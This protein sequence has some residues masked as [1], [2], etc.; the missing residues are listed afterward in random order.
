G[1]PP[2][3]TFTMAFSE[4]AYDER[5]AA[6]AV[7]RHIGSTH[8]ELAAEANLGGRLDAVVRSF[9]EPFGNPTALLVDELARTTR[10]HVTVALAGD[11]GDEV[12]AGYPRYRGGVLARRYRRLPR[13]LR[14]SVLRPLARFI[15]ESASGRHGLRRARE[16]LSSAD[17]P[18]AEMYAA[19][20]EYFTPAER[21]ALLGEAVPAAS[22]IAAAYAEAGSGD[23]LDAM[24]ETDLRTFLPGNLLAYGDAMTMRRSLELRLPMLDHRLVETVGRMAGA[25]RME[26]GGKA[27]LR[28]IAERLLPPAVV[29]RPKIGF[30]PPM[31][32]WLKRDLAP[33]VR[34]RLTADA[35]AAVGI[36]WEP[37]RRLIAE[38]GRGRDHTLKIWSLLA[39]DA[40]RRAA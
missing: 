1:G 28:R 12:F 24:Q 17:R 21:G 7:A 16:F 31:G 27:I 29:D 33:L 38:H 4:A 39:L 14:R 35:T 40:W 2:V 26:G 15:P 19:W 37:V 18:D 11:G 36:A 13:W 8:V 32:V 23:P 30:N 5:A 22:P 20:V 3:R 25:V 10:E 6:R 9:G 34:E